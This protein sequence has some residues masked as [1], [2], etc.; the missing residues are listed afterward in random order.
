MTKDTRGDQAIQI[1]VLW[2]ITACFELGPD[3]L[4]IRLQPLTIPV[5]AR[6]SVGM[7]RSINPSGEASPVH[8]LQ[9]LAQER[10]V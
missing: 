8:H 1:P 10:L 9:W 4:R 5:I 2:T 7:F 3:Q 6:L